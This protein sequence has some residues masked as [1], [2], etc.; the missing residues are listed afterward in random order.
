MASGNSVGFTTTVPPHFNKTRDDY[1]K[2]KRK[3]EIW[4]IITDVEEGKQAGLIILRL[5][6]ETQDA[7]LGLMK[8]EEIK[9]ADGA[10]KVLEH[11]DAMFKKDETV[12]AYEMYE[13]FAIYTRGEKVSMS[14]HITEFERRWNKTK[15]EGTQ[16]TENVLAYRLLKS[17]NLPPGKEQLIKATLDEITFATMKTKLKKVFSCGIGGVKEEPISSL[18]SETFYERNQQGRYRGWNRY[19]RRG[20]SSRGNE[21]GRGNY[22]HDNQQFDSYTGGQDHRKRGKN[23]VDG[24]GNVTNCRECGSINHWERDCPDLK[25]RDYNVCYDR[26]DEGSDQLDNNQIEYQLVFGKNPTLPSLQNDKP[27]ALKSETSWDII[28]QNLA[29]QHVAR[30]TFIRSENDEKL[31]RALNHNIRTSGDIKYFSGD[32]V[33]YRRMDSR[34]WKGPAVVIGQDAQQVLVKHGGVMIRVHPSRLSLEKEMVICGNKSDRR[35]AIKSVNGKNVESSAEFY[36]ESDEENIVSVVENSH[37]H[38]VAAEE[39]I[40]HTRN[41][42]NS[43]QSEPCRENDSGE[44]EAIKLESDVREIESGENNRLNAGTDKDEIQPEVKIIEDSGDNDNIELLSDDKD[45]NEEQSVKE[46]KGKLTKHDGVLEKRKEKMKA[47]MQ[48]RYRMK[49]GKELEVVT[50]TSRAGKVGGVYGA[51]WNTVIGNGEQQVIDFD[52]DVSASG[53]LYSVPFSEEI[54][55]GEGLVQRKC[56][57]THK[58]KLKELE[59]WNNN[60]EKG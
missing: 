29:S 7:I 36:E 6:D 47:E 32:K 51:A 13:D 22:T 59:S 40:G 45:L 27:P 49:S 38:Q 16:L 44:S 39:D 20:D 28:R 60:R 5:D 26:Y 10:Q 56:E 17:S 30:E 2:W 48:V 46:N 50:L 12:T 3:F 24:F 55:I 8:T 52:R 53:V 41:I 21:R 33:Y 1:M 18:K 43:Y 58:A 31:R 23:P 42:D 35:Q 19:S 9:A 37:F 11:L 34:K 4:Q 57:D 15:T 25:R 54:M 14:D